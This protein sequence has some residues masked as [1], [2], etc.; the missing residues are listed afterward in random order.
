MLHFG[1]HKSYDDDDDELGFFEDVNDENCNENKSINTLNGIIMGFFKLNWFITLESK[2]NQYL[3]SFIN[4]LSINLE[5]NEEQRKITWDKNQRK[6][7]EIDTDNLPDIDLRTLEGLGE[8]TTD[9]IKHTILVLETPTRTYRCKVS[10]KE[11]QYWYEI[12][13]KNSFFNYASMRNPHIT[14]LC[15]EI[16]VCI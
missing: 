3:I 1:T 4:I 9:T 15:D 6:F 12:F 5:V 16:E 10:N 14:I 7:V 13:S 8:I 11:G 2:S